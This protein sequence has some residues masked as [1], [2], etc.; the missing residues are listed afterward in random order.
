MLIF[1]QT[2]D[3]DDD[4]YSRRPRRNYADIDRYLKDPDDEYR[5]A[6]LSKLQYLTICFFTKKILL[7]AFF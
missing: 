2:A 3:D 5:N 7:Y 1:N 6:V 4:D